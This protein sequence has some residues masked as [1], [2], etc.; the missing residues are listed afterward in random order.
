MLIQFLGSGSVPVTSFA[1]TLTGADRPFF[2]GN[3]WFLQ[4]TQ[5]TTVAATDVASQLNISASGLVWGNGGGLN[6]N[7]TNLQAY[8]ST[9]DRSAILTKSAAAGTFSEM[10]LQARNIAGISAAIG[11]AVLMNPGDCSSYHLQLNS[12]NTNTVLFRM[13]TNGTFTSLNANVFTSAIND[14]VRLEATIVGGFPVLKSYQNGVLR[15]TTTDNSGLGP[16]SGQFG[17]MLYGVFQGQATIKNY[18]GGCL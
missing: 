7:G 3:N 13:N 17:M 8:P 16:T 4:M 11:P 5:G 14:V 9:V 6:D 18:N 15:D 10:T 1:D 12:A 2:I